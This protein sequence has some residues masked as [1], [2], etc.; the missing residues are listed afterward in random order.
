MSQTNKESLQSKQA[1][2]AKLPRTHVL[3]DV[4]ADGNC[5]FRALQRGLGQIT[6]FQRNHEFVRHACVHQ[7]ATNAVLNSRFFDERDRQTYL[8]SMDTLGTYGDELCI[9]AFCAQFQCA[10]SVFSPEYEVQ[11][12][13][14]HFDQRLLITVV[15]IL[16]LSFSEICPL[17][18][19]RFILISVISMSLMRR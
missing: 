6:V 14:D 10:V 4:L 12:F 16:M 3:E 11:R 9:A 1:V 19:A 15:I 7:I 17:M 8:S 13:G 18:P 5:L 2:C